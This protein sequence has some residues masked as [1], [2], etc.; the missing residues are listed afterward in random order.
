MLKIKQ[1]G[2]W[3]DRLTP[4]GPGEIKVRLNGVWE[5]D[6]PVPAPTVPGVMTE[7]V[8]VAVDPYTVMVTLSPPDD[9]GSPITGYVIRYSTDGE[10]WTERPI[11]GLDWDLENLT[12]STEYLVGARAVNAIGAGPWSPSSQVTTK[13]LPVDPTAPARVSGLHWDAKTDTSIKLA[14]D[15]PDDGGSPITRYLVYVDGTLAKTVTVPEA[16]LVGLTAETQY[17]FTVS[18]ENAIGEG[19]KSDVLTV[20]TDAAP[21]A[22]TSPEKVSGLRTVA[23]NSTT[24]TLAWDEP[25]NGNSPIIGYRVYEGGDYVKDVTSRGAML[26]GLSAST[27][28]SFT[29]SAVNAVGEGPQSDALNVTTDSGEVNPYPPESL[30]GPDTQITYRGVTVTFTN[31]VY[32]LESAVGDPVIITDAARLPDGTE[33]VNITPGSTVNATGYKLHGAVRNPHH[34][35]DGPG[36]RPQ[37]GFDGRIEVKPAGAIQTAYRDSMNVDPANTGESIKVN[38]WDAFT[39]VKAV[40][41]ASVSDSYAKAVEAYVPFTFMNTLPPRAGT[42]HRPPLTAE[43]KVW[44]RLS[45]EEMDYSGGESSPLRNL[46]KPSWVDAPSTYLQEIESE[47]TLTQSMWADT[48]ESGRKQYLIGESSPIQN[49]SESLGNHRGRYLASVFSDWSSDSAEQEARK[50]LANVL[51]QWGIDRDGAAQEGQTGGAG[52]GQYWSYHPYYYLAS[53]MLRDAEMLERCQWHRSNGLNQTHWVLPQMVG[54][55]TSWDVG[56]TG[57]HNKRVGETYHPEMLGIPEWTRGGWVPVTTSTGYVLPDYVNGFRHSASGWDSVYRGT[58]YNVIVREVLP[59]YLL[60]NGPNGEN[61]VDVVNRG[62]PVGTDN[63]ASAALPY[64]DRSITFRP[65][66][67]RTGHGTASQEMYALWRDFIPQDR[68]KGSPDAI[69]HADL[70][71]FTPGADGSVNV[72][73]GRFDFSTKDIKRREVSYSQDGVQFSDP[74]T[75]NDVDTIT[76]LRPGTDYWFRWRQINDDDGTSAWSPTWVQNLPSGNADQKYKVDREKRR[77]TGSSSGPVVNDVPPKLMWRPYHPHPMPYYEPAEGIEKSGTVYCGSG[78]WSGGTGLLTFTYQWQ[79]NVDGAWVDITGANATSYNLHPDDVGF[80]VRCN[81]SASGAAAVSSDTVHVP[82]KPYYPPEV[83]VDTKFDSTFPLY[84]PEVYEEIQTNNASTLLATGVVWSDLEVDPGGLVPRKTA[85]NPTLYIPIKDAPSGYYHVA[86]KVVVGMLGDGTEYVWNPDNSGRVSIVNTISTGTD[87]NVSDEYVIRPNVADPYLYD[88]GF[89]WYHDGNDCWFRALY[90]TSVGG[91]GGGTIVLADRLLITRVDITDVPARLDPPLLESLGYDVIGVRIP[92]RL[93]EALSY[94]VRYSTDHENW[95]VEPF[96]AE[97]RNLVPDGNYYVQV[98]GVNHHGAGPW[99]ESEVSY[100]DLLP[101]APSD[102]SDYVES[103]ATPDDIPNW[104]PTNTVF[105]HDGSTQIANDP[106]MGA[107]VFGAPG[108]NFPRVERSFKIYPGRKYRV[109][110]VWEYQ[111]QVSSGQAERS[112]RVLDADGNTVWLRQ[113]ME[114]SRFYGNNNETIDVNDGL[115]TRADAAELKVFLQI[116]GSDVGDRK[117]YIGH[118]ELHDV[119]DE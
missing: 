82:E 6:G 84:W 83:V 44:P 17:S 47:K 21:V 28:Y 116:R 27:E 94:E 25:F 76:G 109:R 18:A 40:S 107:A 71:I 77:I 24:V 103:F 96:T 55:A 75:I 62:L 14:W 87:D 31:P 89:T 19:G 1:G 101:R 63:I 39:I 34:R 91:T 88:V 85:S 118:V 42:W 59:I 65:V 11:S 117:I 110:L 7:P 54:F 80:D 15:V 74:I 5:G 98:R 37:Q 23:K 61:G 100:T 51:I 36:T 56:S 26:D 69:S 2:T 30:N 66:A 46:P 93:P 43:V 81:V 114:S 67:G 64:I 73:L 57:G 108:Q 13:D 72:D 90:R 97:I 3:D 29:V 102:W 20:S 105:E 48:G 58:S 22:P 115:F 111:R 9:G 119:T 32:W 86:T 35:P 79:R 8:V 60:R 104:S 38:T 4:F 113:D 52:A 45:V 50:K 99:S 16:E 92:D 70:P 33:I 49:Y 95:T 10:S 78:L 53:F 112:V 41:D 106:V 12:P 68:W